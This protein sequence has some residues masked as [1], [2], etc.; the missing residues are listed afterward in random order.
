MLMRSGDLTQ[1]PTVQLAQ[2]KAAA[3]SAQGL[4]KKERDELEKK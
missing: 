4:A 3:D 1:H 2:A